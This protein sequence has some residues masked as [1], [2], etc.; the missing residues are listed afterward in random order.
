MDFS[1]LCTPA[2]AY[3]IISLVTLVMLFVGSFNLISLVVKVL[4][5]LVWTFLLNALCE[6]GYKGVSWALV[7]LPYIVMFGVVTLILE[8]TNKLNSIISQS[9]IDKNVY[10][11]MGNGK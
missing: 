3:L 5:T 11:P 9:V 8:F 10:A 1:D 2:L 6:K 7:L 4:F